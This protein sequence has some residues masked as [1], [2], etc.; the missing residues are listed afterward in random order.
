MKN[1][2][3]IE[4]KRWGVEEEVAIKIMPTN[5]EDV[6]KKLNIQ[7]V[8]EINNSGY[9]SDYI[10]SIYGITQNAETV[11]YG[12]GNILQK[13]LQSVRI[14]D[15]GLSQ[16]INYEATTTEKKKIHGVIP[17]IQ[18]EVLRKEKLTSADNIYSFAMLLWELATEKPSFHDRFHD[19]LL[20]MDI[21]NG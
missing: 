12:I 5:S 9:I 1:H 3:F 2:G 21:L 16:A 17:Y 7:R 8:I 14:G 10:T 15:L 4:Y 13:D 6:F 11:K 19:H 18:P 20:I